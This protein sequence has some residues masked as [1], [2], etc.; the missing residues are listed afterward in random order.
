[1]TSLKH[2]APAHRKLGIAV[3]FIV[4]Y[5]LLGW[6]TRSYMVLPFGITPWNPSAGLALALLLV[7]GVRYWPALAVAALISN[8]LA[9]G[10]PS[11]PFLQLLAPIA[12][13]AGYTGMAALLLGPLGF[14][15]KFD[16]LCDVVALVCVAFLG[17][18]LIAIVF[19][20]A[21]HHVNS[22]PATEFQPT[23]LRFWIGHLIGIVSNTP[24]LLVLANWPAIC[25]KLR[26]WSSIETAAQTGVII[27]V[28]WITVGLA[29]IDPYKLFFLLSIPLTWVAMRHDLIGATFCIAITQIG[30]IVAVLH[31]DL[32]GGIVVTEYQF[33]M[34]ALA[35]TCLFLAM[36]VAEGRA[37]RV[38]QR[39]SD[40]WL[41]AIVSTA[42][43]SIITID[44]RG[45]IVAANPAAARAFG[46]KAERL[47]GMSTQD[48]MPEIGPVAQFQVARELDAIRRDGSHFPAELSV[49][50]TAGG[51]PLLSIA[52]VRDVSHRKDIER[53]LGAK[54]AELNRSAR[55]VAAGEMAAALAHELH[56]PL[57]AIRN[58]A[59]AAQW[60]AP[61]APNELMEKVEREAERA[62]EV[63]RRLREFFRSGDSQLERI[64]IAQLIQ[65]AL[66]PMR[67]AAAKQYIQLHTRLAEGSIELLVDRVQV[68]TVVHSLVGNAMDAIAGADTENRCVFV[69]ADCASDG[70]VRCSVADTGPGISPAIAE[71]LFEP[72]ATTKLTGTGLGLAMSRTMIES[73]GG[74]LWAESG[75]AGGT[76]FH[77]FLPTSHL[78]KVSHDAH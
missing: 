29:W 43:D 64:S 62:A 33:M 69:T 55:L 17:T 14:R 48:L 10:V 37:A 51:L 73:H 50:M 21:I 30:L 70:W 5:V 74:E 46:Y 23:V 12:V 9:R 20:F 41:S 65:G 3:I 16:R 36:V 59:R 60:M 7:F 52:I 49:G 15:L 61:A 57:S 45:V 28:L 38:A 31:A 71:R 2:Q 63:V 76:V 25:G 13:T 68:E 58:Y 6:M 4:S 56:Q 39:E 66:D 24:L 18:L 75:V 44:Q 26:H 77:F 8:F 53:E 40:S 47:I 35:V 54:Q 78:T 34:L 42:P 11:P 67:E 22:T 19:V 72:F 27:L 32:H 1:M